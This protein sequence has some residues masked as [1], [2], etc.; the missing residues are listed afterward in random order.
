[1]SERPVDAI[2]RAIADAICE[3]LPGLLDRLAELA[4]PRAY[5][6]PEVAKRLDLAES[7]IYKLI[8]DGVLP[9]VPHLP[10]KRIASRALDDFMAGRL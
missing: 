6:V 8:S 9:T 10:A 7:T 4:G 5:A 1:M 3:V 2:E